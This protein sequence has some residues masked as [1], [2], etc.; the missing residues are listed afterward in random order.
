MSAMESMEGQR[1]R[2][3][4]IIVWARGRWQ[5]CLAICLLL[6]AACLPTLQAA[7]TTTYVLTDDQG[8]VL[9]LADHQGNV[10]ARFDNRPY[11]MQQSGP[12]NEGPGY[13]GHVNDPDTG[14]VYM[15]ARYY[16]PERGGFLGVDPAGLSPGDAL[17]LN[18]Y[19]Y[20]NNNP[21][22]NIDPDGRE[23]GFAYSS[24]GGMSNFWSRPENNGAIAKANEQLS[25]VLQAIDEFSQAFPEGGLEHAAISPII[26]GLRAGKVEL[27]AARLA[28]NVAKGSRRGGESAAAAFGRQAHKE[29]AERVVQKPGWLSEPRLQ[30]ANGKFYKPD[31][32]T[33]N[34]RILELKPN[35]PSGHA[36]GARQIK[37]YEDQLGM[38]GRV[39][40]Y[41]PSAP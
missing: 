38:P 18:R 24:D 17:G 41:E 8:T 9:A 28:E 35:T 10:T 14:F 16:D 25:T 4:T 1:A 39:I 13:T 37:I 6:V 15:Q 33:P 36:A 23:A 32:V 12:I 20:A 19:A 27:K 22:V 21:I 2:Q 30:G 40:Y 26:A 3:G 5:R 29:F 11:G 34:G 31:V 7:E